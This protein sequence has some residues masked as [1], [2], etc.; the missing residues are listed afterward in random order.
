MNVDKIKEI[1]NLNS[2]IESILAYE[3]ERFEYVET[4][5]NISAKEIYK[6]HLE[7]QLELLHIINDTYYKEA[8][9]IEDITNTYCKELETKLKKLK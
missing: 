4:N 3:G 7:S 5:F 2:T 6:L 1:L 9:T 8:F